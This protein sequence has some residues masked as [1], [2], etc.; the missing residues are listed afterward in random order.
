[1]CEPDTDLRVAGCFGVNRVIFIGKMC[2][3][4]HNFREKEVDKDLYLF[5]TTFPLLVL[6]NHQN[7]HSHTIFQ[8]L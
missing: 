6:E 4:K 2:Q 1:M 7:R 5:I 3:F 8:S